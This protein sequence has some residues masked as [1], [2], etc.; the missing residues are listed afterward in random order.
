MI[1]TVWVFNGKLSD[2]REQVH[3]GSR[4]TGRREEV[5]IKKKE[6]FPSKVVVVFNWVQFCIKHIV[7]HQTLLN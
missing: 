7:A 6:S 2:K 1:V 4:H 5:A 3:E